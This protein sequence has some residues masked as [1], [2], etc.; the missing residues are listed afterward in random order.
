MEISVG[1]ELN[2]KPI[3]GEEHKVL[4]QDFVQSYKVTKEKAKQILQ[5]LIDNNIITDTT[6]SNDI[7]LGKNYK[8]L[9]TALKYQLSL[10]LPREGTE[11]C[12]ISEFDLYANCST[13]DLRNNYYAKNVRTILKNMAKSEFEAHNYGKNSALISKKLDKMRTNLIEMWELHDGGDPPP[14]AKKLRTVESVAAA[15]NNKLVSQ[16]EKNNDVANNNNLV[17]Q[18]VNNNDVAN[19]NNLVEQEVNNNKE[20]ATSSRDD[21]LSDIGADGESSQKHKEATGDQNKNEEMSIFDLIDAIPE[22][23]M[24]CGA[25]IHIDQELRKIYACKPDDVINLSEMDCIDF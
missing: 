22:L 12:L 1:T 24:E 17:E 21:V 4:F 6:T 3:F 15:V 25:I 18:E 2:A 9:L 8:S 16:I 10:W 23:T 5:I 20:P 13:P 14:A 7:L 11:K 19:N